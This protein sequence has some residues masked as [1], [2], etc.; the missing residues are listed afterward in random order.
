VASAG[1]IGTDAVAAAGAE[2]DAVRADIAAYYSAKIM[3][4]GAT[5]PGV[6]WSCQPT[7]ELRFVQILKLCDFGSAFSLNDVGCGYGALIAYLDRR[8]FDCAV[9]YAGVDLSQAM[10][11][12]A[13]RLWRRPNVLF[14]QGH[15][16]PRIA[17][18]SVASGIFNVQLNQPRSSWERFI[19]ET[20]DQMYRTS[21]RGFAVNF[22]KAP[23]GCN[24][25]CS[26]L[27]STEPQRWA[28]YCAEQFG[29]I[30]E[31]LESYGLREFTLIVRRR[32]VVT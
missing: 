6:D 17:D 22:V 2:L 31:I 20:L 29:A 10:I 8:H 26:G 25:E 12:R 4:F 30:T 5:P 11:R 1:V 15:C 16:S 24:P 27:Y 18:Y 7:Q 13:R 3:K 9:D 32:S 14:S 19:A 23:A 28:R 21:R